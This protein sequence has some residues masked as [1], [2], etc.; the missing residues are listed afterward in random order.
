MR[1]PSHAAVAAASA[2]CFLSLALAPLPSLAR[3][4]GWGGGYGSYGGGYG[5]GWGDPLARSTA[6]SR[7]GDSREGR[8]EVSRFIVQDASVDLLGH[9]PVA[10][11][12]L[13]GSTGDGTVRNELPGGALGGVPDYLA[14]NA[15]APFEAAVI[16]RLVAV[17]YDTIHAD[18]SGGQLAELSVSREVLVPAEIKRNPVSGT[19]AMEVGTRGSAYGLAVNVDMTKPRTALLST[20]LDARIKD[21][22]SGK[23]LWE[24]HSTIATREGDDKWTDGAIADRLA[25]ALFD[26]FRHPTG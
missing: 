26:D 19:A 20:R 21:R 16:D 1:T 9:G 18:P 23:I 6:R 24:G 17:G 25:E 4:G 12:S 13:A 8:V 3:P 5:G 2:A 11:T 14:Q 10:V 7:S 15:R 22:A